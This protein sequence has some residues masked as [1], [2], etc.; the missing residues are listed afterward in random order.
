MQFLRA[1][2]TADI[3]MYIPLH[4]AAL[5][6]DW[7]KAKKF[8]SLHPNAVTARITKG[9]ETA[10]HI[11]AGAK[12]TRFVEELVKLMATEDLEL[13]NK[14]NKTALYFAAA[15]GITRIAEIMV[16]KHSNLPAVGG[17][18]VT[19]LHMAALLGNK[20]MV[21][22][23][24]T[25]TDNEDLTEEDYIELFLAAI[26]SEMYDVALEILLPRPRL[27][28]ARDSNGE[29]A[30]HVLAR[31]P[32]AFSGTSQLRI[33]Q[34][35][36]ISW[37][38]MLTPDAYQ[39]QK[40]SPGL[41]SLSVCSYALLESE[42]IRFK[43]KF[44]SR[45]RNCS[46]ALLDYFGNYHLQKNEKE[47]RFRLFWHTAKVLGKPNFILIYIFTCSLT[48]LAFLLT[49]ALRLLKCLW[50]Q[51]LLLDDLHLGKL[52][53]KPSQ[54]LFVA[55]EFGNFE[56]VA[57]LI[58]SHPDLIWSVDK[59][60]RTIFHIAVIHRQE[61]IFK[62][63]YG[64]G[65]HKDLITAYRDKKNN[66]M[67]HLAGILAPS[68]RLNVV[69]GAALQMQRELL[70]FK[71]VEKNVQPL[72]REMINTEG[73][74]PRMKFTLEHRELVREGERW[75]KDTASTCMLVA[76]L[77]TTVMFAA[78][79]TVPG[80]NSNQGTP[81]FLKD[82]LFITF[83]ISDASALFSSV[84]S[85]FIFFS[86][87]TSPCT[88]NDFLSS[89]P[90][91]LI[92]GLTTLFFSIASMLIAFTATFFV[93]LGNQ[94][95]WAIIPVALA[96]AIPVTLFATL[97]FPLLAGMIHSTFGP[98]LFSSKSKDTPFQFDEDYHP[99]V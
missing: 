94:L 76:T 17:N 71:E 46:L 36:I 43:H 69:C 68:D 79:F 19:A 48:D 6:G 37:I 55:V 77:I 52:L 16:R 78:L 72:Y 91:R 83:A 96:T 14:Y 9:G 75:M 65:A 85:T 80:G 60:S 82:K 66:N 54:P 35:R 51:A 87:H 57:V 18:G 11:A 98:G 23:L 33:W 34:R 8:I 38:H 5:T 20:D 26:N 49:L 7:G 64:I 22:F 21:Q 24:Y 50:E 13:R 73:Q 95:A 53:R 30:L 63:I 29:T 93:L 40:Y 1:Q 32:S 47:K 56:F 15:S 70:W 89:L 39:N 58:H 59:D 3:S 41:Y 45:A 42:S 90:K 86:I 10:L 27:A 31:K 99:D 67:L 25:V 74:T 92:I 28:I 12:Q 97:Q 44:K 4:Q 2:R 62:L 88:E 81:N 61:K 84:T